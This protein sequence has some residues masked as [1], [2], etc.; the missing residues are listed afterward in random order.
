MRKIYKHK[1]YKKYLDELWGKL[2]FSRGFSYNKKLVLLAYKK[3]IIKFR[4]L[5]RKYSYFRIN[6][7]KDL[8]ISYLLHY[9]AKRQLRIRNY[10]LKYSSSVDIHKLY[11]KTYVKRV[12]PKNLIFRVIKANIQGMLNKNSSNVDR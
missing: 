4:K 12:K 10:F 8:K 5:R 1:I 6:F 2:I 3:K 9:L 7:V 11:T